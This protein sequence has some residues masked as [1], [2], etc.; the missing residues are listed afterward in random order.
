MADEKMEGKKGYTFLDKRGMNKEEESSDRSAAAASSRPEAERASR[1]VDEGHGREHQR[2]GSVD[3]IT[4]VMSLASS[5]M[6]SMGRAAD[7]ITKTVQK[8]LAL[9]Q[10]NIDIIALLKEKTKGNLTHEEERVMDDVL[11]ELRLSYVE[12]MKGR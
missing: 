4:L 9:A 7:P 10:Q 3:F 6:V 2:P 5:A 11:Y 8:N 12:A 1:P